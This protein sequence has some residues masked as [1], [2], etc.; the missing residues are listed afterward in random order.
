MDPEF[1]KTSMLLACLPFVPIESIEDPMLV[2]FERARQGGDYNCMIP[3]IESFET[4][5]LGNLD[6]SGHFAYIGRI[7][8]FLDST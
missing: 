6:I 2:I 7:K 5:Y 4:V 3:I 8:T 1:A